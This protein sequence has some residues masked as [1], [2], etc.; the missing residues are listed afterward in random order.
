[1]ELDEKDLP[2]I[3]SIIGLLG[4]REEQKPMTYME[5]EPREEQETGE[6]KENTEENE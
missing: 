1:M 4:E 6:E 3:Q 2:L 5:E